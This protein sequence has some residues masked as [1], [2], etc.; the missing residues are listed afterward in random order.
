MS[1][2]VDEY[3]E[4][5]GVS[6]HQYGWCVSTIAGGR[7]GVPPLRGDNQNAAFVPGELWVPKLAGPRTI[8][9]SMWVIGADPD[10]GAVADPRLR[11]NDNWAYLRQLFFNPDAEDVLR[12]RWWCT[13]PVTGTAALV[14]ADAMAQLDTG[15]DIALKM[16]GRTRAEFEVPLR[17]AH[18]YFYGP[19]VTTDISAGHTVSIINGGNT[20][21][22]AKYLYVDFVGPLTNPRLINST[23]RAAI[24]CGLTGSISAGETVT[25]DV[26]QFIAL[27]S[28]T[29]TTTKTNKTG[30]VYNSGAR[31][32]MALLRGANMLTFTATGSGKATVR[33]RPPYL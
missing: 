14:V 6:L 29:G 32:W 24:S 25:L 28:R 1:N 7:L 11:W 26:R 27:S 9:L 5:A 4:F 30:N 17:L 12:R 23:G 3:L 13:D 22:W 15:Q 19:T 20:A 10:G 21:A 31:P 33:F 18:P 8:T 16:T 2:S